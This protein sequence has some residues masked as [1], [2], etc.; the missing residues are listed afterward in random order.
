MIKNLDHVNIVVSNLEVAKDFF[1]DLGFHL[2]KQGELKGDWISSIVQLKSVKA[3]YAQLSL[4]ES[5][6]SIEL[7]QYYC[8]KVE[9]SRKKEPANQIGIRHLAFEVVD[10]EKEVTNLSAKGFKFFSKIEVYPETGKRLV[11][12]YGPDDIIIE[13]AQYEQ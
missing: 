10:I 1:L 3:I 8:P 4:K 12:F 13:M 6:T 5:M 2:I 11:Y 7:I 9:A